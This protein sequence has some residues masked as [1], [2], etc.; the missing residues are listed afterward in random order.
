MLE[1]EPTLPLDDA[2]FD[3]VFTAASLI[4]D[5]SPLLLAVSGGPDSTALMHAAAAWSRSAG[6]TPLSVATVDHGLRA[7]SRAEAEEVGRQAAA[8]GLPHA[9]LDWTDR[10]AGSPSQSEARDAR[11]RLLVA[12]AVAIGATR[13]ATAHTY[14]DQVETILMRLADGSGLSGLA[15]MAPMTQRGPVAHIRPFLHLKKAAL[16]ATCR[17]RGWAFVEDPT[18]RDP[19]FARPRWRALAGALASEGLTPER[20][21]RLGGRMRRAEMAL[22][23]MAETVAARVIRDA[24]P[25]SAIGERVGGGTVTLDFTALAGEPDEIALRVLIRVL[26]L[27]GAGSAHLRLDRIETAFAKLTAARIAA[28]PERRTL[29]GCILSLDRAGLLTIAPELPRRRGR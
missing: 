18:N 26:R 5:G 3:E 20:V 14:D 9:I 10:I 1:A 2:D 6:G 23:A 7:K 12:H 25:S 4:G 15:G 22:E 13:I 24:P 8:V 11:Y 28:S 29:A 17:A 27:A 16:V 19:R 21:F